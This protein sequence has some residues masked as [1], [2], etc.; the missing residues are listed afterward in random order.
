MCSYLSSSRHS[1]SLNLLLLTSVMLVAVPVYAQK[2]VPTVP[3]TESENPAPPVSAQPSPS[4]VSP[5]WPGVPSPGKTPIPKAMP[6]GGQSSPGQTK[7]SLEREFLKNILRD[8]KAIWTAPFHIH[9]SDVIFIAPLAGATAV[10]I[11]TDRQTAEDGKEFSAN[12]THQ[13]VSNAVSR[14]GTAY[15]DAGIAGAFYLVGRL[16]GNA[17]AK[18]TG[19]LAG[20]ALID[21]GIVAQV[22]KLATQRPRPGNDHG[23]GDFL[24]GGS[25]FPS[26]HATAA[27]S[28]AA[29][30]A[31]E[32]H[33]HL[34]VQV[35]SYSLASLVSAARYTSNNH[36]LSDSLVGSAIGF[37]I[38]RYVYR[39][40][41]DP[42]VDG[43]TIKA[44]KIP[45]KYI[46]SVVPRYNGAQREYGLLLAWKL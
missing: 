30:V 31:A 7:P 3:A 14:F 39:A 10:L 24:E 20:E 44:S 17:K 8:Q 6:V 33:N 41:H 18:E 23:H 27:W 46:P 19:L 28:L 4:P 2:Q 15:V 37:A 36:F 43:V 12:A 21:S 13:S 45:A 38:G 34:W 22:L 35:L 11:A 1:R 32:Y 29:V 25:S 40:H 16:T 5:Y 26:G 42:S 9:G